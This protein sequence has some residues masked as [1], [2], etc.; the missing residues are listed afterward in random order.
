MIVGDGPQNWQ[1][2]T[3]SLHEWA[4]AFRI[5]RYT[6]EYQIKGQ[7]PPETGDFGLSKMVGTVLQDTDG[8][9]IGLTVAEDITFA[10]ENDRVEQAEMKQRCKRRGVD[11]GCETSVKS[12]P[13]GT[14]R[15]TEAACIYGWSH[16]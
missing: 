1:V 14:V 8:Q 3:S 2:Y 9:F 11:G 10:L 4:G 16:D 12:F 6:G 7:N 13:K 15:R 5:R